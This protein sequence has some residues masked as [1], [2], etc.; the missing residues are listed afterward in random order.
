MLPEVVPPTA[1]CLWPDIFRCKGA[2]AKRP[3]ALNPLQRILRERF[4]V[5]FQLPSVTFFYR[6][7]PNWPSG[8]YGGRLLLGVNDRF[9]WPDWVHESVHVGDYDLGTTKSARGLLI[10]ERGADVVGRVTNRDRLE[11]SW[12]L[13]KGRYTR[14]QANRFG[15]ALHYALALST[16]QTVALL[17]SEF[18][19]GPGWRETV[20]RQESPNPLHQ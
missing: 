13:P 19:T 10:Q 14:A 18:R 6:G 8:N 12:G 1:I 11:L 7:E 15:T 16:N 9:L 4:D 2:V 5:E 3:L 20:R 17:Q